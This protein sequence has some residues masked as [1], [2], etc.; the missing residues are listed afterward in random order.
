M[1]EDKPIH[2]LHWYCH[3]GQGKG[4]YLLAIYPAAALPSPTLSI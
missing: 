2:P 3:L 4:S 1:Q